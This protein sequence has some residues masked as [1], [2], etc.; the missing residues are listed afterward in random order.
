MKE[1]FG[2]F[3]CWVFF[4]FFFG[5]IR[6]LKWKAGRPERRFRGGSKSAYLKKNTEGGALSG[7]VGSAEPPDPRLTPRATKHKTKTPPE[8]RRP[9]GAW[10]KGGSRAPSPR[11]CVCVC[12]CVC[13]WVDLCVFV[14]QILTEKVCVGVCWCVCVC[15]LQRLG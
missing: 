1:Q 5:D 11:S 6:L 3:F 9:G 2:S 14:R 10:A 13:V 8:P 12:V 15:L 4:F 7:V